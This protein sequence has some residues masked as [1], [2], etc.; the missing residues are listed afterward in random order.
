MQ[1]ESDGAMSALGG[2]CGPRYGHARCDEGHC[3][4]ADGRCHAGGKRCTGAGALDGYHG[5]PASKCAGGGFMTCAQRGGPRDGAPQACGPRAHAFCPW[6]PVD[7]MCCVQSREAGRADTGT[8]QPCHA[9]E[10]GGG[11][12]QRDPVWLW[13]A[14]RRLWFLD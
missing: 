10:R 2:F 6:D 1:R 13:D 3:C 14:Q 7:D 4:G 11:G 9:V 5:P 12:Q 8:C